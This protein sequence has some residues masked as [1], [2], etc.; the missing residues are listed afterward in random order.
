MKID[1]K[2]EIEKS[3]WITA[4]KEY[5]APVIMREFTISDVKTAIIRQAQR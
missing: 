3:S 5:E 4:P 2:K 1:I